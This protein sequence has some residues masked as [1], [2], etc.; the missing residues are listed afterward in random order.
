MLS[1]VC[2]VYNEERHIDGCI[3]SVLS[4]DYPKSDLEVIFVDGG[5]EDKTPAIIHGY[6]EKFP[7]IRLLHNPRRIAPAALNI[8][9]E[10][11]CG[12]IIMR[13]DAHAKYPRDYFSVLTAKLAEHDAWNVGGV[14]RTLPAD[15]SHVC[16]AIAVAMSSPF[17]M[18]NSLFRIGAQ[19]EMK[20]DTV[21]FGCFPRKVFDEVGLFD[22]EL[23]RNQDDEFNGRIIQKGGSIWL[24][25]DVV[26]DY[27]ARKSIPK[28]A[29]MFYQYGLFKPLVNKKLGKPATVRQFFPPLFVAGLLAGAVLSIFSKASACLL[30]SVMALY[31]LMAAVFSMK[32]T[33]HIK[34]ILL[35]CLV[36]FVIHAGYGVGYWMGIFKLMSNKRISAESNH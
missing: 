25:P 19:K 31:F 35:M 3:E 4:Q 5:S 30:L 23:V 10:A 2:P 8:G 21:P 13:I 18:G 11:A 27:Y 26:V 33:R 28:T 15:N 34:E 6:C 14:C 16:R 24:I 32:K 12:D 29:A 17:G 22:E 20:A 1:V 7:F 36:F 9:V